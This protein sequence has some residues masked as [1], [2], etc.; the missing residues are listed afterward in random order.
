MSAIVVV[1]L[2]EDFLPENGS[3]AVKD[4]RDIIEPIMKLLDLKWNSIIVT[5]DWH[6][7][8]HN[9]FVSQ[10]DGVQP[11]TNLIFN[12]P[13]GEIDG[14]GNPITQLL[15]IWPDHCVQDTPGA[16]LESKFSQKFE[17]I[18][19]PKIVVN[20]GYLQDREYYSC[21]RDCWKLHYTELKDYLTD[22]GIKDVVFVGLAYDYC[23]LN[24]AIDC[25]SLGFNSY[26]VKSCCKSVQPSNDNA[27]DKLYEN[28]GVKI[29]T[30]DDVTK[31]SLV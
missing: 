1:D 16:Q 30:E 3:L 2:Q 29:I 13:L 4:G 28:A 6:P 8:N 25:Q 7:S 26:V 10:H 5:K 18:T 23:V 31:L 24:S 27:T 17:Q 11:F 9:S 21:F 19:T 20:K 12:H 15:T 22:N 14:D